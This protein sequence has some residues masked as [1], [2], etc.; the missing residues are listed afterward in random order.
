MQTWAQPLAH[1]RHL[2]PVHPWW[3]SALT[4]FKKQVTRKTAWVHSGTQIRECAVL[5]G[6][7]G[8]VSKSQHVCCDCPCTYSVQMAFQDYTVVPPIKGK[9]LFTIISILFS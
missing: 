5:T 9:A 8:C 4:E 1:S 7:L 2:V 3:L 6:M